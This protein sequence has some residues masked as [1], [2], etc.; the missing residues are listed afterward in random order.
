MGLGDR[1]ELRRKEI[2]LS[3][4]ELARRV[5]MR[6]STM[7]SLVNGNSR[8][9]RYLVQLAHELRTSPAWL[10]GEVDDPEAPGLPAVTSEELGWIDQL[11]GLVPADRNAV[12][13]LVQ[14]LASSAGRLPKP[15]SAYKGEQS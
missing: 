13:Q 15:T 12:I 6:Q 4:A 8:T 5:G 2:G 11:R 1:I 14:S 3:Q 9:T 10:V 7:N